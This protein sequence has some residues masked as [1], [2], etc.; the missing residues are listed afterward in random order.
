MTGHSKSFASFNDILWADAELVSLATDYDAIVVTIKESTGLVR[1]IICR[2]YIGHELVGFWDEVVIERGELLQDDIFLS[3][4]KQRIWDRFAGNPVDSGSEAR[5]GRE[6][7]LLKITMTDGCV[8]N[9]VCGLVEV[10]I[11]G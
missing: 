7:I 11:R 10:R 3:V 5:N 4:C 1:E 2:G 8:L 9:L 6:F